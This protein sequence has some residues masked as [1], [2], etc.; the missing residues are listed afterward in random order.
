MTQVSDPEWIAVVAIGLIACATDLFS[1]RIPNVLTFGSALA[2]LGYHFWYRGGP[3]LIH[4]A[5]GWLIGIAI[6]LPLF[7]LRGMGAGDVKL[8]G[9]F[10]AWLGARDVA[11]V[12]LYASIAGG[13]MAL[14]VAV[15]SR[16]LR[17][18]FSNLGFMLWYWRNLGLQPVPEVTLEGSRGPRL[19]YAF[20]ILA[21]AMLRLWWR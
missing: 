2:G 20:P 10:G 18:T 13:V 5:G 19:A 3:G 15:W 7:F 4:S 16:R 12:A 11:W 6:F 9:A 1:R 17:H 8:L 21:G 14:V